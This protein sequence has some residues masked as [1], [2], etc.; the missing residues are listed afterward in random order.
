MSHLIAGIRVVLMI[1]VLSI[2][3]LGYKLFLLFFPHTD[4]RG[5]K[6]RRLFL[7]IIIVVLGMRI[8]KSGQTHDSPALYVCNHRGILD[9]FI[10]LR[11]VDAFVLSK[12]EVEKIPILAPASAYTGV[13]YVKRQD[14]S[15][16]GAARKAIID[17][18]N[19]GRNVF[20]FPEGTTNYQQRTM[21]FK[22]GAFEEVAKH[23]FPVVPVALEYKTRRDYWKDISTGS[24]IVQQYGK[25]FT[26]C[27]LKFGTPISNDDPI[28]LCNQAKQWIDNTLVE[29]Q[30]DWSTVDFEHDFD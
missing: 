13:I 3:Y 4:R 28:A 24:M 30:Q 23:G 18:L 7:R 26:R 5:F 6:L 16:R 15:S 8:K 14:K 19:A 20:V 11:Y 9:F 29:M 21:D 2:F 12:A 10:T 22:I 25:L 1:L 17:A 27:K